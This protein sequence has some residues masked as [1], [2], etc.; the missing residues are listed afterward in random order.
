MNH[1]ISTRKR[2]RD[3]DTST[4]EQAEQVEEAVNWEA[5]AKQKLTKAGTPL[6]IEAKQAIAKF[7]AKKM[8]EYRAKRSRRKSAWNKTLEIF[9]IS[10]YTLARI[11][12]AIK[13]TGKV[14]EHSTARERGKPKMNL[15]NDEQLSQL[16]NEIFK[17]VLD[18]RPY[19][20]GDMI[21]FVEKSFKHVVSNT[22]MRRI[23]R[24]RLGISFSRSRSFETMVDS[25]RILNIVKY[26]LDRLEQLQPMVEEGQLL[27]VFTDESY[28]HL[29][30]VARR[31]W[32]AETDENKQL[33][34]AKGQGS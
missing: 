25:V 19:F 1:I 30:D 32:L 8:I 4:K 3:I 34:L 2:K 31:T 33:G 20:L 6:S 7:Y 9:D 22:T 14:L 15:L 21:A 28:I 16:R 17:A 29:V 23:V 18:G 11:V 5:I 10:N 24:Q 12:K 27:L 13:E 26:Y